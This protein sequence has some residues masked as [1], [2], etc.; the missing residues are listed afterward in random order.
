M[1]SWRWHLL[2]SNSNIIVSVPTLTSNCRH[3]NEWIHA[4]RARK[5]DKTFF[6]ITFIYS[7]RKSTWQCSV[8]IN[9]YRFLKFNVLL[10]FNNREMFLLHQ[11]RD[12]YLHTSSYS[13]SFGLTICIYSKYYRF[14]YSESPEQWQ[15]VLMSV[16]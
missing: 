16:N 6:M 11:L 3:R 12:V 15:T 7:Y 5:P 2:I 14:V 9:T 1:S 8:S 10:H 13:T 4:F